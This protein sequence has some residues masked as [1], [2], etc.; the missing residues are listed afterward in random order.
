MI[1][2]M[3]TPVPERIKLVDHALSR[4][5]RRGLLAEIDVEGEEDEA[6]FDPDAHGTD[7]DGPQ[8]G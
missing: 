3:D 2:E 1:G 7:H 4:V 6:V 8:Y 5:V